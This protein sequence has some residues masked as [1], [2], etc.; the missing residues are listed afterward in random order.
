MRRCDGD[1]GPKHAGQ[2]RSNHACDEPQPGSE[3]V[4]DTAAP[5]LGAAMEPAS[6]EFR[7]LSIEARD[8]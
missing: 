3:P 8:A 7:A 6:L 5:S 1:L 2:S 4:L